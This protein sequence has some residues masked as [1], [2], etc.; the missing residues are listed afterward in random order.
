MSCK[1]QT[2]VLFGPQPKVITNLCIPLP[3][4]RWKMVLRRMTYNG[5]DVS[6]GGGIAGVE[7]NALLSSATS[8]NGTQRQFLEVFQILY[9]HLLCVSKVET[10]RR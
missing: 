4:G 3:P 1:H 10:Q 9:I 8:C 7:R 2:L 6:G 5:I